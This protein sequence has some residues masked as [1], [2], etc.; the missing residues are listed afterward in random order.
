M[1]KI[2]ISCDGAPGS[3]GPP[4]R[5]LHYRRLEPTASGALTKMNS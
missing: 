5:R 1:D 4:V 3:P 2:T